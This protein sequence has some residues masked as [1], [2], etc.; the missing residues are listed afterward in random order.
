MNPPKDTLEHYKVLGVEPGVSAD[1]VRKAYVELARTWDPNHHINNPVLRKEAE[2]RWKEIEEAYQAIKF[3]LPDLQRHDDGSEQPRF[4][5]DFRELSVG[6]RQEIS[7]GILGF[8]ALL[9]LIGIIAASIFLYR[10]GRSV[11]PSPEQVA[12]NVQE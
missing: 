5:R 11:A 8:I 7:K 12:P 2:K 6:P 9:V 3:F 4:T 10:Y 1:L